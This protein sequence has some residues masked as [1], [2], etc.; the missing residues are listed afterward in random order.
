MDLSSYL[1]KTFW[2]SLPTGQRSNGLRP[3]KK[4]NKR[5]E[6]ARVENVLPELSSLILSIRPSVL[7][8]QVSFIWLLHK[9]G[10]Y[11]TKSGYYAIQG[12]KNQSTSRLLVPDNCNRKKLIWQ[13]LTLPKLKFF[14]RKV[15]CN[16]LPT[17]ENLRK[18][19]LLM[20]T[21]CP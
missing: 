8:A 5:M 17:G 13:S 16:A 3:F 1:S 7:G 18:R 19:G 11:T 9:S 14:L 10:D 12:G 21:N 20:N 6:C 4:R 15:G 2:P